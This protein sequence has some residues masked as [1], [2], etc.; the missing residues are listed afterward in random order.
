[1]YARSGFDSN[2]T[3][4]D[5][6]ATVGESLGLIYGYEFDGIYQSSDF[7]ITP[8]GKYI[9]KEGIVN[10]TMYG[11]KVGLHPGVVKYKDQDG[12][13]IITTE[14]R[15]V[16]GNALPKWYGGITNTFSYTLIP[17]LNS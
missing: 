6:I 16:I 3:Q 4:Y 17:Q 2:F 15:T 1:M 5:Y 12:N 7:N 9:L 8:D 11:N 10:N 14:D 13:G